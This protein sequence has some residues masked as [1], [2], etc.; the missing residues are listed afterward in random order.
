MCWEKCDGSSQSVM[1]PLLSEHV[2]KSEHGGLEMQ[3]PAL[4]Q[5]TKLGKGN[6]FSNVCHFLGFWVF[7][8]PISL[9]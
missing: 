6:S 2:E 9:F 5:F 3:L 1:C 7:E 8:F 4:K